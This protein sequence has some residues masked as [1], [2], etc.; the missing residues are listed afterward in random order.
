MD[1]KRNA[2]RWRVSLPVRYKRLWRGGEGMCTTMDLS[3]SGARL[4]MLDKAIP[5]EHMD[6]V[7][8]VPVEGASRSLCIQADVVW[9]EPGCDLE[10]GCNYLTGVMFKKIRDCHKK[11]ILDCIYLVNPEEQRKRWWDVVC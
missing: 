3:T 5:G 9:Q 11:S 2:V 10:E 4:S 8:G 7:L 1:E 6:L